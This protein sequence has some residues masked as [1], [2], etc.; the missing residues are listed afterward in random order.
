MDF[1]SQGAAHLV[2][3]WR[4]AMPRYTRHYTLRV[5]QQKV[6]LVTCTATEEY[7]DGSE[8]SANDSL[9][10]DYESGDVILTLTRDYLRP[11]QAV[12][13]HWEVTR[14]PA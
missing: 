11:N 14:E 4:Q 13:L 10:W 7:P 12:T 8:I 5:R 6:Q 2:Y 9:T 1:D 3:Y